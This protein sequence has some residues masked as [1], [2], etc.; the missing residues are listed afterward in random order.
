LGV[1]LLTLEQVEANQRKRGAEAL[2]Y[3]RHVNYHS[4]NIITS[5]IDS[6]MCSADYELISLWPAVALL[7]REYRCY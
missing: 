3:W 4:M 5:S 2:L 7:L 1:S 6:C